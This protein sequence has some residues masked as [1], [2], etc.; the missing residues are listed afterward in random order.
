[1][2]DQFKNDDLAHLKGVPSL[3][4]LDISDCPDLND[5]CMVYLAGLTSLK[6]L[7]MA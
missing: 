2:A 5:A 6:S 7:R 4:Q 3:E 1:M